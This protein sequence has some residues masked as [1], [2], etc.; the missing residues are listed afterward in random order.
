MPALLPSPAAC[1][2]AHSP[3]TLSHHWGAASSWT[4][5][6]GKKKRQVT[7]SGN[8]LPSLW[9]FCSSVCWLVLSVYS[10]GSCEIFL[11][12]LLTFPVYLLQVLNLPSFSKAVWDS[13]VSS[14]MLLLLLKRGGDFSRKKR[15]KR[16]EKIPHPLTNP[17][18][19]IEFYFS[20][21]FFCGWNWTSRAVTK[22]RSMRL[23]RPSLKNRKR[24]QDRWRKREKSRVRAV[25]HIQLSL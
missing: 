24:S 12:Q 11:V 10:F 20:L 1:S 13:G 22:E 2:L 16:E 25:S 15:K 7:T 18:E 3:H 6:G 5:C 4:G 19:A 21:D 8:N 23:V 14:N 9:S 17:T